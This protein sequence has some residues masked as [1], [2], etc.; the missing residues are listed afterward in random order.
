VMTLVDEDPG[1]RQ[2]HWNDSW[3]GYPAARQRMLESVAAS[4]CQNPVMLGGDIHAFIVADQ[5]L[6]PHTNDSPI[7]ASEIVTSSVTSN[8]PPQGVIDAY[9]RP[10]STDVF[11][12]NGSHRGYAHLTLTPSHLEADIVGFDTV[13]TP[14]ATGRSLAKFVIED[15]RRGLQRA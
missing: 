2:L 9:N 3:A 13:R 12:A 8:P 7:I 1:L 6:V 14:Q 15:G 11:F 5:R 10:D 4:G